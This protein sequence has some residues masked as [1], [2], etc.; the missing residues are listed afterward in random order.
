MHCW[1]WITN[2]SIVHSREKEL[3][4]NMSKW[5]VYSKIIADLRAFKQQD[6]A[7]TCEKGLAIR[8]QMTIEDWFAWIGSP[9]IGSLQSISVGIKKVNWNRNSTRNHLYRKHFFCK[10]STKVPKYQINILIEYPTI[11]DSV[12]A[13]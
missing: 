10:L 6:L 12:N 7:K 11:C 8:L 5:D 9:G 3:I 1:L 13:I 4:I 2:L